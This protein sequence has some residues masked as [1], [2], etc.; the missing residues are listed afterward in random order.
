MAVV[1]LMLFVES[2]QV[3]IKAAMKQDE[4]SYNLLLPLTET[5]LDAV[6]SKSL[7]KSIQ[8]VIDDDGSV[9]DTASPEL[10]RYR[11]Q[12]QALESRLC[13]LMDKLIRNADNEASLSEV[14]IVNGRCCIKITGDK[15]SSFD[16]LLLSSG[17]DA[18]SMIEPI[19][20]VPLNDELQGARALVVRAELE[21]L[22]KLTDKILLELDNIQILMQETVTL[23]KVLL[24][25]ITHFP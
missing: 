4:D 12:V 19:V 22:S 3:T 7:V 14:S 6:V 5:I 11:D 20:A 13:Q 2:L 8:D 1:S 23:D 10:R 24:F 9:K 18:G 25:F 21:A 17:S 15:S 16:G